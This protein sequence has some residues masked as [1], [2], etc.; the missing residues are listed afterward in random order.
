MYIATEILRSLVLPITL[1]DHHHRLANVLDSNIF[2]NYYDYELMYHYE[3][4]TYDLFNKYLITD[5]VRVTYN[6]DNFKRFRRPRGYKYLHVILL[7]ETERFENYSSIY[8]KVI[9]DDRLLFIVNNNDDDDDYLLK[10]YDWNRSGFENA[11]S[12]IVYNLKTL[13]LYHVKYYDGINNGSLRKIDYNVNDDG[14]DDLNLT[15][16]VNDYRNFNGY[17]FRVGYID[18][19][20]YFRCM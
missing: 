13:T 10:S 19:E 15:K 7:S 16:Y 9:Y 12:L 11:A 4:V 8:Y 14:V 2:N 5:R 18:F 17:K 20:P 1:N 3:N 6:Y